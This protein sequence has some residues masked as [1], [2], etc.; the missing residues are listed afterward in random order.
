[1]K[2]VGLCLCCSNSSNN[3]VA[4]SKNNDTSF[5]LEKDQ[6]RREED[7]D[8]D[9]KYYDC[10]NTVYDEYDD[11]AENYTSYGEEED[12]R[13]EAS[14]LLPRSLLGSRNG[15]KK[16]HRSFLHRINTEYGIPEK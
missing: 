11:D 1:M 4:I 8:D 10:S 12:G 3:A 14:P 13:E 6:G 9:E 16:N 15:K 7:D 5:V 2:W